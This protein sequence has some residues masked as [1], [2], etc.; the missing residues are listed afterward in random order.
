MA[1][2]F[3]TKGNLTAHLLKA[4]GL[5][6]IFALL[7]TGCQAPKVKVDSGTLIRAPYEDFRRFYCS[8]AELDHRTTNRVCALRASISLPE[9]WHEVPV[10]EKKT[11]ASI[12]AEQLGS[13][14]SRAPVVV[15]AKEHILFRP[16]RLT[17]PKK[18]SQF[19]V[20]EYVLQPG[21]IIFVRGIE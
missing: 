6:A 14:G 21:D 16:Q 5:L 13:F 2:T 11:L 15:I 7:S 20:N 1:R 18:P 4:K 10:D 9:G 12:L 3:I 8:A 19:E 17:R